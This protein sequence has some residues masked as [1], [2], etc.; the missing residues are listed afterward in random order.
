[1]NDKTIE[2]AIVYITELFRNNSGG[3]D[4]EHTLRVYHNAL[5]IAKEEPGCNA[6]FGGYKITPKQ[7]RWIC[8]ADPAHYQTAHVSDFKYINSREKGMMLDLVS[9]T[10]MSEQDE[11]LSIGGVCDG[12]NGVYCSKD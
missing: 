6:V 10:S 3:H 2:N 9:N 7:M 11:R 8:S 1:M 12:T 5:R 4:A